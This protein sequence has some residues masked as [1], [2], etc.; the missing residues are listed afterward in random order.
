[1]SADKKIKPGMVMEWKKAGDKT[2]WGYVNG[3]KVRVDEVHS[4]EGYGGEECRG[5]ECTVL[6]DGRKVNLWVGLLD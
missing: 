2:D 4:F 6:K 5:A 3:E 1:M